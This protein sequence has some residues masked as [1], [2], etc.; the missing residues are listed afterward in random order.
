MGI[1]E[2]IEQDYVT[3]AKAKDA[4]AVSALR[5]IRAALKNAEID[6][7]SEL[8]ESDVVDI[9]G[10]E[11]KKLKDSIESFEQGGREDLA[12]K[13]KQE[14]EL[15]N[16]YLPEQMSDDELRAVVAQ[17]REAMGELTQADFGRLMKEV[18]AEVK[19]RAQGNQVSALVKEELS[20]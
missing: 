11:V 13:S 16:K 2:R 8:E 14:L 18:M 10:K 17:K 12:E 1:R 5:M 9:V 15:L 6:K 4:D 19:G 3:A 7:M 20:K